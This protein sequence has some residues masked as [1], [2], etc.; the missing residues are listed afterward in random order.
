MDEE[1][2]NEVPSHPAGLI[3]REPWSR[4]T[5]VESLPKSTSAPRLGAK[6]PLLQG[7]DSPQN[8]KLPTRFH[9][10][11]KPKAHLGKLLLEG[12]QKSRGD[13]LA[14]TEDVTAVN[15]RSSDRPA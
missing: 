5:L 1:Q 9:F 4:K 7:K 11:M 6:F 2:V 14:A 8:L 10:L 15:V 13:L 3:W 12:I